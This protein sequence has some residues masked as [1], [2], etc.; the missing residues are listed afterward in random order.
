MRG[1]PRVIEQP[2]LWRCRRPLRRS[3][4]LCFFRLGL[5][6]ARRA[7]S[8]LLKARNKTDELHFHRGI[9]DLCSQCEFDFPPSWNL[10]QPDLETM[11]LSQARGGMMTPTDDG[12]GWGRNS[13]G[14]ATTRRAGSLPIVDVA[15]SVSCPLARPCCVGPREGRK[16][17]VSVNFYL[18]SGI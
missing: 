11:H 17:E 5:A 1:H 12:A 18:F 9:D 8:S 3:M 10:C 6:C 7:V 15:V 2:M 16:H 14:G 4:L 13:G